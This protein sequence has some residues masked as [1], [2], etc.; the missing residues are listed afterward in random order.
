MLC[1]P[2]VLSESESVSRDL[3]LVLLD[4]LSLCLVDGG[5][6]LSGGV[7]TSY[8]TSEEEKNH[9]CQFT[10]QSQDLLQGSFKGHVQQ[11]DFLSMSLLSIN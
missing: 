4:G 1:R 8:I 10:S 11:F 5:M 6:S 3:T 7:L 2:L 9:R